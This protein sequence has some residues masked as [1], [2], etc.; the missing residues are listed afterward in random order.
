MKYGNLVLKS[1]GGCLNGLGM[2]SVPKDENGDLII[3]E[4]DDG[5]YKMV[6]YYTNFDLFTISTGDLILYVVSPVY[7]MHDKYQYM[8]ISTPGY[9]LVTKDT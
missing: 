8:E 5:K 4:D 9:Y 3:G 2:K 7:L 6:G 1:I